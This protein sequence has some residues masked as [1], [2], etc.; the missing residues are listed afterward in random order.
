MPMIQSSS[1]GFRVLLRFAVGE[2]IHIPVQDDL[3]FVDVQVGMGDVPEQCAARIVG[4]GEVLAVVEEPSRAGVG[5]EILVREGASPPGG[6]LNRLKPGC[7]ER[8]GVGLFQATT[9]QRGIS[10]VLQPPIE[11]IEHAGEGEG[12][13]PF[14]QLDPSVGAVRE[15][16]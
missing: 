8:I 11:A 9:V 13:V 5:R 10:F 6:V 2:E 12:A 1:E 14:R 16:F 4:A 7:H 3:V 15:K